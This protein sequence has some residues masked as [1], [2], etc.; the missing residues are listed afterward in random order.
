VR[1]HLVVDGDL[2]TSREAVE[3]ESE[4]FAEPEPIDAV[5]SWNAVEIRP[6]KPSGELDLTTSLAGVESETLGRL[7]APGS[8]CETAGSEIIPTITDAAIATCDIDV[9][10]SQSLPPRTV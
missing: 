3:L 9:I 7:G 1:T 10:G 4:A 2:C 6:V 5:K 8:V